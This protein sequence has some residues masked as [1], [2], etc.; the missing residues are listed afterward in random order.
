V[1]P[2]SIHNSLAGPVAWTAVAI[3]FFPGVSDAIVNSETGKDSTPVVLKCRI[4]ASSSHEEGS[5][6]I[7]S[8]S[9]FVLKVI[10]SS[11]NVNAGDSILIRYGIDLQA[12]EKQYEE[13][14]RKVAESSGWAGPTPSTQ[15][16]PAG[17]LRESVLHRYAQSCNMV[18]ERLLIDQ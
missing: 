4:S 2:T 15:L 8:A 5:L 1:L 3:S 16:S 18:R 11:T 10:R 14:E 12:V 6:T 17:L 9:C 7:F 13:M